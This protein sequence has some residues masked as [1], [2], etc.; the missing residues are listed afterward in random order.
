M[1]ITKG[2]IKKIQNQLKDL[3]PRY[4]FSALQAGPKPSII[5]EIKNG[6]RGRQIKIKSPEGRKLLKQG[7]VKHPKVPILIFDEEGWVEKKEICQS[8]KGK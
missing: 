5:I 6:E 8:Q 7:L 1:S 3:Q 4:E 2:Q